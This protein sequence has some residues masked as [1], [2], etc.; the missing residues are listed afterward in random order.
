MSTITIPKEFG[1][2]VLAV[3]AACFTHLY[4]SF[5]VGAARKKYN[6]QYP[7]M[8]AEKSD[9][10]AKEFNCAQRAHQNTLEWLSVCQVLT[11]V[12]GIVFPITAACLM[13]TWTVGRIMYING[14][15]SG[16]PD[17]RMAGALVSH[18]GDLPL[19][20]TTFVAAHKMLA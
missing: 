4:G 2:C 18:F 16:N 1:W 6:I 10:H 11:L 12:N 5:K 9:A 14:Y 3:G 20:I 17:K 13:G 15:G 7:Q 8:Y 19:V